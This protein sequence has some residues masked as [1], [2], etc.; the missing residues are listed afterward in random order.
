MLHKPWSPA[1]ALFFMG[2]ITAI[3]RQKRDSQRVNVYL[4][5]CFAFGLAAEVAHG[6]RLGQELSV[7]EQA[8]LSSQELFWQA[9]E[10]AIHF[11]SF[12]PRSVD[13]VVRHLTAKGYDEVLTGR[14]IDHLKQ[15]QLVDDEAFARYW[16]EQR[17]SFKPRSQIALRYELQKKGVSRPVI[18]E[19]V[20]QVD[21]ETTAQVLARQRSGRLAHLPYP[22]FRQKLGRY[23]QQRGFSYAIIEQVTQETWQSLTTEEIT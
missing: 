15:V 19:V 1:M 21:E 6:L 13:E 10:R 16:V 4:D 18:D 20:Q 2:I 5:H 23:L 17:E 7:E 8:Q 12:R 14:I 3:E 22:E 11:L 9:K